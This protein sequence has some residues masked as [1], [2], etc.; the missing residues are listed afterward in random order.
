MYTDKEIQTIVNN[1]EKY[2]GSFFKLIAQ[3]LR[4]ADKENESKLIS[5]FAKECEKYLNGWK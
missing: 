5:V 2:G 1:M 3:A 4:K